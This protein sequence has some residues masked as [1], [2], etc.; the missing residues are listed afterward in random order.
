MCLN[1]YDYQ[2]KA[3]RYGKGLTYFKN[4]ATQSKT[5]VDSQKTKRREQKHKI[6]GKNP[7]TERKRME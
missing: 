2:S 5:R 7:P 1:L 6:K 3:S 4:R